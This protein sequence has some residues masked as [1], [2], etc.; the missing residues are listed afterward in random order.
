MDFTPLIAVGIFVILLLIIG[1]RYNKL[2]RTQINDRQVYAA[3]RAYAELMK[4]DGEFHPNEAMLLEKFSNEEQKRLSTDYSQESEEFKFVWA[5]EE[6]VFTSLKTCNETQLK[7]FFDNL[8]AM[9]VIDGK[10][11]EI[12]INLINIFYK[13]I[14]DTAVPAASKIVLAMFNDWKARNNF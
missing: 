7:N 1:R 8:F 5:K 2:S 12:E 9:T 4:V 3:I 13:N 6:N 14:T 10:I 11:S